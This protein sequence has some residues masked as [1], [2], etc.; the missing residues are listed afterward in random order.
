MVKA[1]TLTDGQLA[2]PLRVEYLLTRSEMVILLC[3]TQKDR[4]GDVDGPLPRLSRAD[5]ITSI[6]ST[7]YTAGTE[8][9]GY[10]SDYTSERDT[11]AIAA[12]AEETVERHFGHMFAHAA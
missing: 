10:W 5:V 4:T 9:P 1:V 12:W 2:I 3:Y 11:A 8:N 7:L 6:K